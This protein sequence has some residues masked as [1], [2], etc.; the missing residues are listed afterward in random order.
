MLEWERAPY[1]NLTAVVQWSYE[2][3]LASWQYARNQTWIQHNQ[4][5]VLGL[6]PYTNYRFRIVLLAQ[7]TEL[8]ASEAS[9]VI[10]TE[11]SGLPS[12]PPSLVRATATDPTRVSVS[13]LPGPFPNGPVLSYV[14]SI[15]EGPT[16]Y[17]AHKVSS[18]F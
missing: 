6:R 17:K 5:L 15:D 3:P 9:L 1:Q 10:G 12:S 16:G 2:G 18:T 11:P 8:V 14:V 13:W 4:V 7:E